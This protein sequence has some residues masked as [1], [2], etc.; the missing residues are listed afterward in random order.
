ML[1]LRSTNR[2]IEL[3]RID[4]NWGCQS[5]SSK[6]QDTVGLFDARNTGA[7]TSWKDEWD[8]TEVDTQWIWRLKRQAQNKDA[9]EIRKAI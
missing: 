1:S 7:K 3:N 5:I 8:D 4:I 2:V 6:T 9:K